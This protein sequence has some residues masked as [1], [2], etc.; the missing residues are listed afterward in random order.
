M[1]LD[2]LRVGSGNFFAHAD[3]SQ[4]RDNDL[5][6]AAGCLRYSPALIRQ[7]NRPVGLGLYPPGFLQ[8]PEH[9]RHRRR[10]YPQP[11][12][13]IDGPSLAGGIDQI[14]DQLHIILHN[15]RLPSSPDLAVMI[16]LFVRFRQNRC[17]GR[18]LVGRVDFQLTWH[19]ATMQ[20]RRDPANA[21][22]GVRFAGVDWIAQI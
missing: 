5:M 12:C 6:A 20:Q 2:S 1:V 16:R 21:A 3:G 17:N 15:L 19:G 11:F 18:P 10:G 22:L 13:N 7:E 4:E 9:T 14:R 8:P